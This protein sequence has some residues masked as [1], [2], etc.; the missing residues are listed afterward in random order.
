[1]ASIRTTTAPST[2]WATARDGTKVPVSLVYRKGFQKD[3][4]APLFQYAYG[5]YGLSTDPE[6]SYR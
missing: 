3:G 1:M 5:S 6:F 4:T 2:L